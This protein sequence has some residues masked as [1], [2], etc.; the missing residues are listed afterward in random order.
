MVSIIITIFFSSAIAVI[1]VFRLIITLEPF[2]EP[3]R[4]PYLSINAPT[5][6]WRLRAAL[7]LDPRAIL[8][9]PC[10]RDHHQV[11]PVLVGF[12]V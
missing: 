4:G 8:D 3:L 7:E 9:R 6:S 2:K 12:R 5:V 1:I 10:T 11:V